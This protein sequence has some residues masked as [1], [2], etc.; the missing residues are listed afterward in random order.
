MV[1]HLQGREEVTS[2][3]RKKEPDLGIKRDE[4]KLRGLGEESSEGCI[5]IQNS[6]H[7]FRIHLV[8][9]QLVLGYL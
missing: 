9:R 2:G 8:Q 4:A 7:V 5:I 3:I 1:H 6:H